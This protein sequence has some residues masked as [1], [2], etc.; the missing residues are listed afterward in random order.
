MKVTVVVLDVGTDKSARH[1]VNS[2][3]AGDY[4]SLSLF[5]S[6]EGTWHGSFASA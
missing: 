3:S 5:L 4:H 1:T 2:S 6:F